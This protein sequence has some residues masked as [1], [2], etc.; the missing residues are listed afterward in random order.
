MQ[1]LSTP[2]TLLRK[3]V[4]QVIQ[5]ASFHDPPTSLG[6]QLEAPGLVFYK[7]TLP[8]K[9]ILARSATHTEGTQSKCPR[10]S[11]LCRDSPLV[12][13]PKPSSP[14]SG[15]C[16]HGRNLE[17]SFGGGVGEV[18]SRGKAK[19]PRTQAH[20]EQATRLEKGQHQARKTP[21]QEH[22]LSNLCLPA[23]CIPSDI[24]GNSPS[25]KS[26]RARMGRTGAG[27]AVAMPVSPESSSAG[28]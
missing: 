9:G 26:L 4:P 28:G 25:W 18:C 17:E 14:K 19:P 15:R 7:P 11:L 5:A 2:F 16:F 23:H 27:E 22:G 13:P 3:L 20:H 10:W 24:S 6:F 21:D 1:E 8:L 12:L